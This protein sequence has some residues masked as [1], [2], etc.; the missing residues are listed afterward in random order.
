MAGIALFTRLGLALACW[1]LAQ[2]AQALLVCVVSTD[3]A[4]AYQEAAEAFSRELARISTARPELQLLGT[5]DYLDSTACAQEA[6]LVVALGSE[7]LR[8]VS[9]RSTRPAVIAALV[10]RLGFERTLQESRRRGSAPVAALYLDQPLGRQVDLLRLALPRA[11]RVGVLWGPESIQQQ[12][13]LG[14]AL[15]ARGL[16]MSDALVTEGQPLIDP[17]RAALQDADVLLAMADS[18]VY[19]PSSVSNILQTSY[20]ARTPLMAFSPAYVKA[21]ALLSLHS[22]PAQLGLQAAAMAHQYL[23]GNGLPASQYPQDFYISTNAYVAR[24]LGLTL[25]PQALYERLYKL[26]KK[27]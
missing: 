26:E 8:Q 16:E 25:E 5:A 1:C 3:K 21:G 12:G 22:T 27:P 6:R 2:P 10:P 15:A 13:Q 7:A 20:R 24:S 14:A 9:T 17:L 11:R 23:Q 19:N 18:A 4:G